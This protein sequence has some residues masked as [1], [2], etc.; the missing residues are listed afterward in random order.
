MNLHSALFH[1][2]MVQVARLCSKLARQQDR[3]DLAYL[4]ALG[5]L[6]ALLLCLGC[7]STGH[8]ASKYARSFG[9]IV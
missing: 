3:R 9:L 4:E 2:M 6:A 8:S 5:P 1:S 7:Y